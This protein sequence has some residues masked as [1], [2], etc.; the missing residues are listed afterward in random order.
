MPNFLDKLDIGLAASDLLPRQRLAGH[1]REG[2]WI[3]SHA[4]NASRTLCNFDESRP[5]SGE[6]LQ[7]QCEIDALYKN[8]F[9]TK[10]WGIH[11]ERI[12]LLDLKRLLQR[13]N[14]SYETAPINRADDK[15]LRQDEYNRLLTNYALYAYKLFADFSDG[16]HRSP[17]LTVL[18][19][20]PP[21]RR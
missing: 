8:E 3:R 1:K 17:Y 14:L 9:Q 13:I 20:T 6:T 15:R 21:H 19:H 5:D 2:V 12:I 16:I 18:K 11:A 7:Q 4:E 10:N